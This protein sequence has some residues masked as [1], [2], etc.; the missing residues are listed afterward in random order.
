[1]KQIICIAIC[2]LFALDC[3]QPQNSPDFVQ[4]RMDSVREEARIALKNFRTNDP[5]GLYKGLPQRIRTFPT[6]G[7]F[8]YNESR[9]IDSL[10][11][12]LSIGMVY[13]DAMRDR[14]VQL[15]R[16]E[17]ID[18]EL[19]TLV[20]QWINRNINIS[21]YEREAMEIIRFDTISLLKQSVDSLLV[22]LES[23]N[24]LDDFKKRNRIYDEEMFRQLQLDT[25]AIFRQVFDSIMG[26]ERERERWLQRK[27]YLNT[28]LRYSFFTVLSG[29]INDKRFIP[30]LIEALEM[31]N[32]FRQESVLTALVRMNV[33]PYY[34]DYVQ[35]RMLSTEEIMDET[36]RLDF[37]LD[38]FVLV[39]G[40][41]EIFLELSKYLLSNKPYGA[42][43]SDTGTYYSP[44]SRNAFSL[45]RDH[46]LNKDLQELI[47]N[48]SLWNNPELAKP[49][50]DWM[51]ENYGNYIIR[52][53]W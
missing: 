15:M 13:D 20:N 44:V 45:I 38:D 51:K 24:E 50:Y 12:N 25:T 27:D 18:G 3:A 4:S 28:S 1:M 52:K 14:I 47:E 48:K 39:L 17:Y 8:S 42:N 53:I 46:I 6:A 49:V 16:N 41:Q 22:K 40:T 36:K 19:D 7:I 11:L 21:F 37:Q 33:E 23:R 9:I 34:S 31:P 32:Y 5:A 29:L 35:K 26:G 43:I 2:T 30:P 10:G